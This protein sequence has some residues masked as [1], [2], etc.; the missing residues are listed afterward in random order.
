MQSENKIQI[1]G[2]AQKS[3]TQMLTPNLGHQA[4]ELGIFIHSLDGSQSSI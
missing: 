1:Y 4:A 3:K 2:I